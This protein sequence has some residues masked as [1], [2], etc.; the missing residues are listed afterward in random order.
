MFILSCILLFLGCDKD[1]WKKSVGMSVMNRCVV[2]LRFHRCWKVIRVE[3]THTPTSSS[4]AATISSGGQHSL[5]RTSMT[6]TSTW[7]PVS[8]LYWFTCV[9]VLFY[10]SHS[11][12]H[13][14]THT[15]THIHYFLT[16]YLNPSLFMS[17]ASKNSQRY[18]PLV[19]SPR[20]RCLSG[21]DMA[22]SRPDNNSV[23][24]STGPPPSSTSMPITP[25]NTSA[26]VTVS[27]SLSS[28]TNPVSPPVTVPST[29]TSTSNAIG[30]LW[31][32]DMPDV[33][34]IPRQKLLLA[35]LRGLEVRDNTTKKIKCMYVENI[36]FIICK[37]R[38][39]YW[40]WVIPQ[41]VIYTYNW[42]KEQCDNLHT[43]MTRLAH[44][45]TT[46]NRLLSTIVLQKMGL[47]H[48]QP[49]N[50]KATIKKDEVGCT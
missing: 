23:T 3:A 8:L 17:A 16:K 1:V 36:S 45:T 10:P 33:L 37:T 19:V 28:S 49:F 11:W 13:T 27:S 46:R 12:K 47:Y 26:G 2:V 44:W 20:G 32:G 38:V 5:R 35:T 30:S 40:Y 41:L 21:G 50:R 22:F 7:S 43:T 15:H 31:S 25:F 9:D 24:S 42:T 48:N 29:P 4:S 14:H 34:F 39:W 18:P 6:T